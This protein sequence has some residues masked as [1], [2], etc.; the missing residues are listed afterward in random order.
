MNPE[1]TL[2]FSFPQKSPQGAVMT[3]DKTAIEQLELW[4]IYQEHW[5]EHKPSITVYYKD[6]EFL[7]VGQWLY[8]N[9]DSVSG[10]S[11]LPHSD[12]TYR[13]A[14]YQKIEE[15]EYTKLLNSMPTN[16]NWNDLS[17]YEKDDNTSGSQ[18]LSCT[19]GVCEVVDLNG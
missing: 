7:E 5:C 19:G 15:S 14:P 9:F 10:V 3:E 16:I 1:R 12:H 13:Q 11:F 17:D 6:N 2:I 4:K 8:N 18:E